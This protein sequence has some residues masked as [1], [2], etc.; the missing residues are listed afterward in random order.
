MLESLSNDRNVAVAN[1][2]EKGT[3]ASNNNTT[4][5]A[6]P[7]G[8]LATTLVGGDENDRLGFEAHGFLASP[9]DVDVYSFQAKPGT[10][11]WIG[12]DRTLLSL[13]SLLELIDA[14]RTY[15]ENATLSYGLLRDT[16]LSFYRL[17]YLT[18]GELK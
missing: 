4:S 9:T 8:S 15:T 5:T 12:I 11:I 7:L 10:E 1:E 16:Y 17:E 6:H 13:D 2:T 3:V 18:G 14:V